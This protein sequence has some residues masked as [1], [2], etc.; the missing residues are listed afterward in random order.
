MGY[1]PHP[2]SCMGTRSIFDSLLKRADKPAGL[3][4]NLNL[5]AF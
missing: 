3:R 4:E 1:V 2:G 5:R